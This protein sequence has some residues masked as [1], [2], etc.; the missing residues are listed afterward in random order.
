M[1][2]RCV[3]NFRSLLLAAVL[4]ALLAGCGD[5]RLSGGSDDVDNPALTVTLRSPNGLPYGTGTAAVYA[6][7]HNPLRDSAPLLALPVPAG[8]TISISDSS[9]LAAMEAAKIR[10]VPWPNRDS[11]EFNLVATDIPGQAASGE[12]FEGGYL[13]VRV[14]AAGF[15]FSRHQ[16]G[17][18]RYPDG[19]GVLASAPNMAAPILESQGR[20]GSIGMEVG[21]KSVFVQ[22]SPYRAEIAADGTFILA[23]LAAGR[24]ELNALSA[25]GKIYT[26]SDSLVTGEEFSPSDWSE[27]EL[28]WIE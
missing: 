12:A 10:G 21:L 24:Y 26:A 16:G 15:Q 7:H 19:K 9:L 28:I 13:L 4:A 5:G 17:Q 25:D 1:I 6:R 27:A 23:R 22:G 8:G 14:G 11:V 18:I 3:E 20:V 2:S